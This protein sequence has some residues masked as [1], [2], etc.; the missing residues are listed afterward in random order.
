MKTASY[1]LLI[2]L[3]ILLPLTL[4]AQE[5]YEHLSPI[6]H[7]AGRTYVVTSRGLAAVGLNPALLGYDNDKTLEIQ[8]FPLS[9]YGLDAGPSFSDATA[10]GDVFNFKNGQISDSSRKRISSLLSNGKLSGRG[11]AEVFGISYHLPSVGTFAL[12]WTTH[13]GIRTD[14]PQ[15]F[16]DFFIVAESQLV[17]ADAGKTFSNFDLQ[18]MWYSEYSASFGTSVF[19]STDSSAFINNFSIGGALKYVS[20]IA[21]LQ[22]EPNNYF[23]FLP[24]NGRTTVGDNFIVRSAYGS[25]FDPTKIPNH[26]SFDFLTSNQAGS[27]IGTDIGIKL[28]L[29]GSRSGQSVLLIGISATDIGTITWNTNAT[30][31]VADH[32]SRDIATNTTIKALNDSLSSLSGKLTHVASFTTPLPAMFRAGAQFDLDAIGIQW[33][34][35]VP[36]IAMEYSTGLTNIVGSLKTGRLGAGLTLEKTG[37]IGLRLNGG[38]VVQQ[39]ANDITLGVGITLF[40]FLNIDLASAHVGQFFKS[41]SKQTDIALG[42][43]AAF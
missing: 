17:N 21:Y 41:G 28:G 39:N 40:N 43:K 26:F 42:I 4:Y 8:V 30:E 16:L 5:G 22:L 11:D 27:G 31:R 29:F 12:T 34:I 20:G 13:A 33:G 36:K 25:G 3:T 38:F 14:I 7:G 6:A 35:F 19:Q 24:G 2:L 9:T 23:S 15:D 37:N 1:V 32:L 18:G 10:L